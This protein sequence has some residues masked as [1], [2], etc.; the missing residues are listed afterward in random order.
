MT[1]PRA[2]APVSRYSYFGRHVGSLATLV[3]QAVSTGIDTSPTPALLLG[4]GPVEPLLVAALWSARRP[5]QALEITGVDSSDA[6]VT[7]LNHL[8]AGQPVCAQVLADLCRDGCHQPGRL[9]L[10]FTDGWTICVQEVAR[11]VPPPLMLNNGYV[12]GTASR[13]RPAVFGICA[14]ALDYLSSTSARPPRLVYCGLLLANMRKA[15]PASAVAA[16]RALARHVDP[17]AVIGIGSSLSPEHG[18]HADLSDLL[19]ARL[20]VEY[21][22]L[23]HAVLS[24][25]KLYADY[26]I[27]VI[28][29]RSGASNPRYIRT[30][31]PVL[32]GLRSRCQRSGLSSWELVDLA[33]SPQLMVLAAIRATDSTWTVTLAESDELAAHL[34]FDRRAIFDTVRSA[35]LPLRS[36][37]S[38]P[39]RAAARR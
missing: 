14:D 4:C 9:N 33:R 11:F 26:G 27:G 22:S 17:A 34:D 28:V 21:V 23:E 31:Q 6:A 37:E 3:G 5:R 19:D 2:V 25:G 16:T 24:D 35:K 1:F 15:D 36:C 32:A 29:R 8:V 13:E 10:S 39:S 12:Q 38:A 7:C 18:L 20:L 30:L